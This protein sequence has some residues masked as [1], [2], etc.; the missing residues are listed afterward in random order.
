MQSGAPSYSACAPGT[1]AVT[2]PATGT[3]CGTI[4]DSGAAEADSA[5][6]AAQAA[7]AG[8]AKMGV[9]GREEAILKYAETLK[10]HR[11]EI[12]GVLVQETGKV[13]SNA[14]YDFDMLGQLFLLS[15]F[16]LFSSFF[17][18]WIL[19]RAAVPFLLCASAVGFRWASRN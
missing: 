14:Q 9:A 8:W 12:V 3:V 6:V 10:A 16:L 4:D 5:L 13:V 11:D 7:S 19:S 18:S 2:D 1:I 15:R 17:A